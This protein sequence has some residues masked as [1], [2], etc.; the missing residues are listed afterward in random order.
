VIDD[1]EG[2]TRSGFLVQILLEPIAA[3]RLNLQRA[4]IGDEMFADA[5]PGGGGGGEFPFAA[6]EGKKNIANPIPKSPD[7]RDGFTRLRIDRLQPFRHGR[8]S[9]GPAHLRAWPENLAAAPVVF[10]PEGDPMPAT[11]GFPFLQTAALKAVTPRRFGHGGQSDPDDSIGIAKDRVVS[12]GNFQ[13]CRNPSFA[14]WLRQ[15]ELWW[16][17]RKRVGKRQS[18]K[19]W[20]E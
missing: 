11:P 4:E 3:D 9:F 2:T 6:A 18:L 15:L 7:A 16:M 12:K 20:D 8:Q 13:N 19:G 14:A 17:T 1:T 5:I 10:P